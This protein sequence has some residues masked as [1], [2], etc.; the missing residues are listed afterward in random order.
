MCRALLWFPLLAVMGCTTGFDRV[1]LHQQLNGNAF[2]VNDADIEKVLALKPQIRFPAN[3]AVYLDSGR[4]GEW[5]WDAQDKQALTDWGEAL[6]HEGIAASFFLIPDLIVGEKQN[7]D[8]LRVAAAR[9]GADVLLVIRGASQ[10]NTYKNATAA[11][12]LTVVGGYVVPSTHC[13]SLFVMQGALIDVGNGF[14]YG[15]VETEGKGSIV[16]PKFTLEEKVA[17]DE[18]RRQALKRFGPE[19]IHR[20]RNLQHLYANKLPLEPVKQMPA[21]KPENEVVNEPAVKTPV[22]NIVNKPQS[23]SEIPPPPPAH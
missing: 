20:M 4:F 19:L 9:C 16:R 12:N 3:V 5:R 21:S 22:S 17:T 18:A 23:I 2:L 13:D 8:S 11:L 7:L 15:S 14:V 1:A 10:N 6:K